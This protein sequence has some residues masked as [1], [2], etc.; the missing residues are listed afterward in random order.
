[1]NV[2]FRL[3]NLN[4]K[5]FGAYLKVSYCNIYSYI[6]CRK[7]SWCVITKPVVKKLIQYRSSLVIFL[8]LRLNNIFCLVWI[9][10]DLLVSVT[11]LNYKDNTFNYM[12]R[13]MNSLLLWL[14]CMI[15]FLWHKHTRQTVFFNVSVISWLPLLI[16]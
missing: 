9:Q 6:Y 15:Q 7:S 5:R 11:W 1:M 2:I 3:T 12:L 13:T 4:Q 14:I 16:C 8:K 10:R